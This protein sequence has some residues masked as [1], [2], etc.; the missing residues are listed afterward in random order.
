MKIAA[1]TLF[2]A[3]L[4]L[5][6]RADESWDKAHCNAAMETQDWPG[7]TVYC[8]AY[9]EDNAI[10]AQNEKGANHFYDMITEGASMAEVGLAFASIQDEDSSLSAYAA[11]RRILREVL[12]STHN[13]KVLDLAQ[14]ALSDLPQD[15]P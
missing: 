3:L 7:A 2:L 6:A 1:I 4:P 11:A 9:A 5:A 14:K 12:A 8:K 15:T 13:A 10:D